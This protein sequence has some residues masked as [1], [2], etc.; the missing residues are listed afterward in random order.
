MGCLLESR[1]LFCPPKAWRVSSSLESGMVGVNDV[2]ISTPETPFGGYK[3]SGI[4]KEGSRWFVYQWCWSACWSAW[5]SACWS[6]WWWSWIHLLEATRPPI[7]SVACQF[8]VN[9]TNS[10]CSNGGSWSNYDVADDDVVDDHEDDDDDDAQAGKLVFIGA[11]MICI[12][13]ILTKATFR[14]GLEEYSNL[15]LIDMGGI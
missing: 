15:K 14:H 1:S 6:A 13:T 5:W 4:G 7:G 10:H 11:M 2:A 12:E 9:Y 8:I 3:T